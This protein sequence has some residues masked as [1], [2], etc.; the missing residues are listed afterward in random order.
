VKDILDQAPKLA[1]LI[2]GDVCLDRWCHYDPQLGEPSRET[3][4]PRTGVTST[5]VTPGAA[6]TVANNLAALGVGRVAV[7]GVIGQDGHGFEL[8]RALQQ[9]GID[10]ELL[11]ESPDVQT[12][13]YT[14]LIN[15]RSGVEDQPRI[16]FVNPSTLPTVAVRLV[17]DR[18]Q[19]VFDQF[20]I[21]IVA[22]QAEGG[23]GGV[24]NEA[25]RR[26]IEELA[27]VYP[28]KTVL[29]DSRTQIADFRNVIAKPNHIEAGRASSD[30]L[31]RVDYGALREHMQSPMLLVTH[32]GDGV[33]L[34]SP[35]GEQWVRT[36]PVENPVDIC[37]AGDS[38]AA[39][40]TIAYAA[41]RDAVRAA[42]FGNRVA[43][44]TIMKPGTGTASPGEVMGAEG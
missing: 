35:G 23:C 1:A 21:V 22:D 31:G 30:L 34:V 28:E 10:G 39:G 29:V 5:E 26:L 20:D 14:K 8:R 36:R 15:S 41:T 12:F 37:G 27:T 40:F 11:V 3:G 32:G 24:V 38:F 17:L 42:G 43:S 13:T 4:I 16:D 7:L 44:I 19:G 33:L 18:L 9:R 25:M 2:V 6:G